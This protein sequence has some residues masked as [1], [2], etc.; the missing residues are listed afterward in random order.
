VETDVL[1]APYERQTIELRADGEGPVTA[2]L[3]RRRAET[4]TRTAVLYL[5]GFT[6]YFFQTHLADFY[7]ARGIDFY[8]IDLRKYGRSLAPHQTPNF[9]TDLREYYEELDEAVRIIRTEDG[10]DRLLLNGHSTGGLI[11]ALWAHDRRDAGLV[12]ALFLNSAFFELNVPWLLRRLATPVTV[13]V[14]QSRPRAKVPIGLNLVYGHSIHHSVHGS[15]QY[16]LA[17]KP[18][19]GYPIYAGWMR[20]IRA[21]QRR[22]QAGL[23]IQV[24]ILSAA[25]TASHKG[26]KWNEAARSAD[27]VLDVEHIARW[28][29]QLGRLVTIARFEGGLHDLTLSAEPVRKRVFDEVERWLGAYLP[30][31]P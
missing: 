12:D 25:S 10:H 24:P 9:C 3:V 1:G 15:W 6:D 18:L 13:R 31:S 23:D 14:G 22:L 8:A 17:W 20:A 19:A 21:G 29:S 11:A 26:A 2:T 30:L 28:S 4:P 7:V 27:A 5:H 16:D